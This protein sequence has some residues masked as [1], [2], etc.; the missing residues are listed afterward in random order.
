MRGHPNAVHPLSLVRLR[1]LLRDLF[2][3]AS[4]PVGPTI[5]LCPLD[6]REPRSDPVKITEITIGSTP[7]RLPR[8]ARLLGR[9][10][11]RV[12]LSRCETGLA[13]TTLPTPTTWAT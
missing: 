5:D 6:P 9:L 11:R 2:S 10:L 4:H 7:E 3:G 12:V 8:G 13:N 1:E